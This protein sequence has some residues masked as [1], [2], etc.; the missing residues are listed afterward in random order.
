MYKVAGWLS[1]HALRFE[2]LVTWR[3]PLQQSAV[4][5]SSS[6]GGDYKRAA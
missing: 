1:V 4:G 5:V 3:Q 6:D 2:L